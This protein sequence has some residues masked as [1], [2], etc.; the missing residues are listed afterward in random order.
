MKKQLQ[1]LIRELSAGLL[2]RDYEVALSLL[3]ALCG[4]NL[5]M[6]GPPGVGKSMVAARIRRA[7]KGASFFSYL[8]SRFSTPDELFG[9]VSIAR[10]K[11]ED[12]YCRNVEGY[13][14]TASV[15][16]LDEIWKAGPGILNT[17]LTAMNERVYRNGT[18]VIPIQM[19]LLVAA[20]NELPNA[21]EGLDALWD[22]FL[23]RLPLSPVSDASFLSLLTLQAEGMPSC[24]KPITDRQYRAVHK[25][26]EGVSLPQEA[27]DCLL[28]IREAV[29]ELNA[30]QQTAPLYISDR[31][32]LQIVRLLK[33]S[34]CCNDRTEVLPADCLLLTPCIWEEQADMDK[35]RTAIVRA[36]L[37][38][39]SGRISILEELLEENLKQLKARQ[40]E[41]FSQSAYHTLKPCLY[42]FFYYKLCGKGDFC[43]CQSDYDT[44]TD[45]EE[46]GICYPEPSGGRFNLLR[47]VRIMK[48]EK[49]N[50]ALLQK[51]NVRLRRGVNTVFVDGVEYPLLMEVPD[52]ACRGV[53]DFLSAAIA[54]EACS[55][56]C[57]ELA[58]TLKEWPQ[59]AGLSEHLFLSEQDRREVQRGL[60]ELRKR[61]D[62]CRTNIQKLSRPLDEQ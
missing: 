25:E 32:W 40:V 43:I 60:K 36:L 54:P 62:V 2:E 27:L 61:L 8:M 59:T 51:M 28:R 23:M 9:P 24:S 7:F 3:C 49:N 44:L 6:I 14:P 18:E 10:L 15:V 34:A 35:I 41:C 45:K 39:V 46:E 53:H 1:T 12:R 13:L 56:K 31:R 20:S 19:R 52:E 16:F 48:S 50:A 29:E 55:N 57:K 21:E 26:A 5:F 47:L 4:E 30:K 33:T 38:E 22:R 17:L 58:A 42:N 37:G 11:E